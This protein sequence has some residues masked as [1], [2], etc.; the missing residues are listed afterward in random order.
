VLA[1]VDGSPDD[2][3]AMQVAAVEAR[4]RD[5]PL[6]LIPGGDPAEPG[7]H[8]EVLVE[9][10]QDAA[11]VVVTARHLGGYDH[12][13]GGWL[14]DHV[15]A[16]AHCPVFVV[17]GDTRTRAVA[18]RPV[19]IAVD[20]SEHSR[21]AMRCAVEEALLRDVPLWVISLHCVASRPGVASGPGVA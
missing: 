2:L 9:Q 14:D 20:G 12:V 13:L 1:G 10:S 7:D 21:A 16:R 8:P 11:L 15:V 17:R 19:L 5:L 18:R 3:A 6:R 4:R